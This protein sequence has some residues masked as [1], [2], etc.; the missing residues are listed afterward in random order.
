M[1]VVCC[2]CKKVIGEKPGDDK[3]VS[4]GYCDACAA[5]VKEELKQLRR[6]MANVTRN[7]H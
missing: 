2:V 7:A 5:V 4:H 3:L 1:K 6:E